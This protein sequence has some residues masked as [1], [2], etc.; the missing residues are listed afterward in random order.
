MLPT[1]IYLTKQIVYFGKKK[2]WIGS[3]IEKGKLLLVRAVLSSK[4]NIVRFCY[5]S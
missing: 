1:R 5:S 2:S 3:T 4:I